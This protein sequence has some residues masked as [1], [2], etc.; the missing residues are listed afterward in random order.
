MIN[1][2]FDKIELRKHQDESNKEHTLK[3]QLDSLRQDILENDIIINHLFKEYKNL[4]SL[5]QATVSPW[6]PQNSHSENSNLNP[7]SSPVCNNFETPTKNLP[8]I[9]KSNGGV[10]PNR[11]IINNI[12][13]NNNGEV[14]P[15]KL[16]IEEHFKN[17]IQKC[18]LKKQSKMNL[19]Y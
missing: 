6:L 16:I 3:K 4:S 5:L 15:N 10:R 19:E 9:S 11:L 8:Q 1:E 7:N 12:L 18:F 17:N 13:R 2:K 14:A